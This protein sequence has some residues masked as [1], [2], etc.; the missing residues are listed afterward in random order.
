MQVITAVDPRS[1]RRLPFAGE[2]EHALADWLGE[3]LV[4]RDGGEPFA[5]GVLR[6]SGALDL[7]RSDFLW[8]T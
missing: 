6:V 7:S 8:M 5:F 2:L 1:A 4:R 3:G